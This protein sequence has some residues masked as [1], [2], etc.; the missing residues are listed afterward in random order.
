MGDYGRIVTFD[1]F[2]QLRPT[3][4]R[5]VCTSG[6]YDP[7]HPGHATC[8][9]ESKKYGDTLVVVVNGDAF[10]RA[11]KGKAFQDLETRCAIVSCIR[12]VDF[13]VPFE[14]ENDQTVCEALRRLRPHV[15]TKG[16]D[17]TDYTNI[18]EWAV[19]QEFGIQ[20]VPQVGLDKKWS[21]SDFLREWGEFWAKRPQ[22]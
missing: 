15:F 12:G 3:L 11:K 5:I 1:E 8:I 10:L 18:P 7:I 19:C 17:R 14:I 20:I 9:V 22:G 21:S 2:D 13:V 4:G 6:G 16:G